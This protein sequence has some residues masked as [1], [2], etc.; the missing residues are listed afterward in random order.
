MSDLYPPKPQARNPVPPPF[1]QPEAPSS[2]SE[3]GALQGD[4]VLELLVQCISQ[5]SPTQKTILAMYYYEDLEIAEIA[6][7]VGLTEDELDQVRAE[8]V[9]LLRT[10]LTARIRLP[11]HPASF[12]K[13]HAADGSHVLN[14]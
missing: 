3:F 1:V 10:I 11:E 8:T 2:I 9:G 5:L 6:A 7:C 12:D 4:D 13:H 14:G